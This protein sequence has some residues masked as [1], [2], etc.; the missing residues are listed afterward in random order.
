[1]L[2]FLILEIE[3]MTLRFSQVN[4]LFSSPLYN[5]GYPELSSL[6]KIMSPRLQS[7]TN[8]FLICEDVNENAREREGMNERML[9]GYFKV[10]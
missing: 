6:T 1:M 7:I 5:Y 3:Q 10:L 4:K 8:I 2:L 9:V